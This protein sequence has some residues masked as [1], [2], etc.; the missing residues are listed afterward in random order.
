M[1][2]FVYIGIL[3][4][5]PYISFAQ[6]ML[7]ETEIQ[8]GRVVDISG[9]SVA[10]LPGDQEQTVQDLQVDITRGSLEGTTIAVRNDFT[11]VKEG[12][13]ILIRVDTQQDGTVRATMYERNRMT[14]LI[15][16]LGLFVVFVIALGGKQGIMSLVSLSASLLAILYIYTP[17]LLAGFSPI[18]VSIIAGLCIAAFAVFI[19]HGFKVSTL[20]AYGATVISVLF[21]AGLALIVSYVAHFTGY[22]SEEAVYLAV[23]TA[24]NI[25]IMGIMMG[26]IIIGMLGVLDDIAV[27]QVS[28]V[29]QLRQALPSASVFEIFK[30]GLRVG[31]DHAAA[32]V[33]TLV[34]AYAGS[35]LPLILFLASAQS[36]M[37]ILINQENFA[38]EIVRMLVGSM[39][40]IVC[41][42]IATLLAAYYIKPAH[43]VVPGCPGCAA[44]GAKH[45]HH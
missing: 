18:V 4:L 15:V 36:N 27:T 7:P 31:K 12:D 10:Y 5:L 22:S 3:F 45:T 14:P 35:S 25:D 44:G 6:I 32:L 26:G 1:K 43:A 24:G 33:N 21:A 2:N 28:V 41:V 8:W 20:L 39:G 30:K 40:L 37:G 13:P 38:M 16:L 17:L 9:T 19:T 42:P 29:H 34:L 23:N 11:M